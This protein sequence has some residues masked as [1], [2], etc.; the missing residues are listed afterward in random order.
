MRSFP[1]SANPAGNEHRGAPGGRYETWS[2]TWPAGEDYHP[3]CLDGTVAAFLA[4]FDE[5][6]GTDLDSVNA[7]GVT[8]YAALSPAEVLGAAGVRPALRTA[9]GSAS[10]QTASWTPP[11]AT[12]RAAG[13]RS[14]WPPSSPPTA[15]TS[16]CP[17][18]TV[19]TGSGRHGG[20]ATPGS[21]WRRNPSWRSGGPARDGHHRWIG[22][23]RARRHE[24]IEAVTAD[25]AGHSGYGATLRALLSMMP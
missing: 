15:T 19:N 8:D 24:L 14:T 23:R 7:L 21:R 1:T 18:R 9:A 20:P 6:G 3:A 2:G 10:E 11:S 4:G 16:A 12:T 5:R 13:R 22:R 17:S 25:W